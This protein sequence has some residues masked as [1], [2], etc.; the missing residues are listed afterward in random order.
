[1]GPDRHGRLGGPAPGRGRRRHPRLGCN[2]P[3]GRPHR[4]LLPQPAPDPLVDEDRPVGALYLECW[5]E[6][7]ENWPFFRT[8]T[9]RTGD[10]QLS[11]RGY[12]IRTSK[13][14][15][16]RIMENLKKS[17]D[18]SEERR[19]GKECRSRWSPYH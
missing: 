3:Q 10:V 5:I 18:R 2:A 17:S 8:N 1:M 9:S 4:R 11:W 12:S 16:E 15:Q 14:M 19:V 13:P 6:T 7:S